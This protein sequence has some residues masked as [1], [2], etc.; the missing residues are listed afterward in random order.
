MDSSGREVG[1]G[2]AEDTGSGDQCGVRREVPAADPG[3]DAGGVTVGRAPQHGAVDFTSDPFPPGS[4]SCPGLRGDTQTPVKQL[5]YGHTQH[6]RPDP[7]FAE[8]AVPVGV[9]GR[10]PLTV[11]PL[12]P[13]GGPDEQVAGVPTLSFSQAGCPSGQNVPAPQ[14]A[15]IWAGG[16]PSPAPRPLLRRQLHPGVHRPPGRKRAVSGVGMCP[17]GSVPSCHQSPCPCPGLSGATS[18]RAK[19][20]VSPTGHRAPRGRALPRACPRGSWSRRPPGMWA[21]SHPGLGAEHGH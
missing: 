10:V 18:V 20:H 19:S 9:T 14:R 21:T 17:P 6:P 11:V 7:A 1:W 16:D 15:H 2:R 3:E 4:V 5:T 8:A 12:Q 13:G